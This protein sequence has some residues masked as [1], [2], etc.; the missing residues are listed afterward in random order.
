MELTI[1]EKL[2]NEK[3]SAPENYQ[4]QHLWKWDHQTVWNTQQVLMIDFFGE[5][6]IEPE[7]ES[8][9]VSKAFEKFYEM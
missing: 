8:D 3:I 5:K 2:D 9:Q 1:D 4:S 6:K 7:P